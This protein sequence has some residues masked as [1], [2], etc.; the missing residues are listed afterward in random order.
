[1]LILF[2][3]LFPVLPLQHLLVSDQVSLDCSL[4][5]QYQFRSELRI[6][7]EGI[8]FMDELVYRYLLLQRLL[9]L[10]L[11]RNLATVSLNHFYWLVSLYF[12]LVITYLAL[13]SN[14]LELLLV[15]LKIRSLSIICISNQIRN[16]LYG[17]SRL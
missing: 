6:W 10:L 17:Q 14:T 13:F 3:D 12:Q 2:W 11:C 7:H 4:L 1:M 9:L 16:S 8:Q 15:V 5:G